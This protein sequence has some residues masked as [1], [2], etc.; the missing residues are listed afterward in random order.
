MRLYKALFLIAPAIIIA[1]LRYSVL[2]VSGSS[3]ESTLLD[4]DVIIV[5]ACN[6]PPP[7]KQAAMCSCRPTRGQIVV[8][9]SSFDH[10]LMVK[11]VIGSGGDHVRVT[12]ATVFVNGVPVFE[13][14]V[15]RQG[16]YK[17]SE[18]S[19]PRREAS[20][21]GEVAVHEQSYFVM[22]D[23]RDV[24]VDSRVLGPIRAEMLVG[25]VRARL[26]NSHDFRV[27]RALPQAQ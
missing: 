15:Y 10:S 20:G 19:W 13:P 25:I 2:K 22:G 5:D 7:T 27:S 3:M 23:N 9:R 12:H 26:P 6:W 16:I 17:A 4:G 24:S 21:T 18:E 8:F 1:S 14:Y 11:R